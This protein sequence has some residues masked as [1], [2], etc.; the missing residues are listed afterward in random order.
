VAKKKRKALKGKGKGSITR[1]KREFERHHANQEKTFLSLKKSSV[2]GKKGV[3]TR[4][5]AKKKTSRDVFLPNGGEELRGPMKEEEQN[6]IFATEKEY[7]KEGWKR[8][9]GKEHW[10]KGERGI[11]VWTKCQGKKVT[12]SGGEKGTLSKGPKTG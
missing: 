12:Q 3:G 5:G 1:G 4:K 6:L 10:V 8:E 2:G 9:R 7:Q 11:L